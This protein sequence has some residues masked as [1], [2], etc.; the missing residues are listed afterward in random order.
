[1]MKDKR[2]K[3]GETAVLECMATGSPKPKLSWLKNGKPLEITP[4]HFFTAEGQLLIIVQ[5][6]QSDSGRYTC[7]MTNTLGTESDSSVV[8]VVGGE[9]AQQTGLGGGG[10]L[11]DQ[12]TTIGIIIIAVV[13]CV[14]GT[15]L[16]WVIII[17]QT[18]K[19][20]E[21]YSSTPTD[22]I[23]LPV[24]PSSTGNSYQS[25]EKDEGHPPSQINS[26]SALKSI[27]S[28]VLSVTSPQV[29]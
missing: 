8:T 10:G 16:V 21:E 7:E 26:F 6:E 11:S 22:E 18:R 25:S 24:D 5:T 23:T 13:C 20:H 14:V 12:S 3:A 29:Q 27:H 2:V 17:Y 9:T 19:K 1:M 15:S 4:R 28:G